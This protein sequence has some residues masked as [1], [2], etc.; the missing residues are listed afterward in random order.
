MRYK[1]KLCWWL[2]LFLLGGRTL[3]TAQ[4]SSSARHWGYAVEVL[5]GR[6]LVMDKYQSLY[7][8][9]KNNMAL[10]A[11]VTYTT[12][13]AD[14][15]VV[16]REYGFPTFGIGLLYC[17]NHR[18]TMHREANVEWGQLVPVAY[19]SRLGNTCTLYGTFERPFLRLNHWQLDYLLKFGI[20]Y[21]HNKYNRTNAIDN[22]LIGSRW[23][24]F[25]G[26][27]VQMIYR[28]S[29]D[30]GVQLGF[31][32]YHHSNGALNRPNKGS[33]FLSPTIGICCTP[34]IQSTRSSTVSNK[35]ES[36]FKPYTYFNLTVG[37]GAKALDEDWK[38]TQFETAPGSVDYRTDHF[39]R[40]IAYS[41]QADIMRRYAHRWASGV[42]VDLFYGSYAGHVESLDKTNGRV[43]MHSPWSVGI[44][45]KH[46]AFYHSLSCAMSLGTYLYRHMGFRA[47]ELEKPYYERVGIHYTLN[48]WGRIQVGVNVKAH[49]TKA[50]LTEV[51]FGIPLRLG[52][53]Q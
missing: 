44:A 15:D 39:K 52:H 22:E 37:I 20:G 2:T 51:S 46:E 17:A 40:Y 21:S 48:R 24:F 35:R 9:G 36:L 41:L 25:F 3:A 19:E 43:L 45:A 29:A 50:D 47:R 33:N 8:K 38:R 53:K 49:L 31:S 28:L 5:P 6:V 16:D 14:S 32:Y 34:D 18:V 11:E 4:P 7:Q 1:F 42:G 12:Q 23:L 13:P 10:S 30:W 27:G 26:T